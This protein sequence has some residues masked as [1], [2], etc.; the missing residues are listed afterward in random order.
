M[1]STEGPRMAKGDI[2]GDGLEDVYIC[3]AKDQA[4]VIYEQTREGRFKK[5]N[6]KLFE[7]DKLSEDTDALFFDA[8][9]DGDEDLYVCSGGNE[10]SPN[11]TALIDRLYING[12]K[13]KFTMSPQVLPSYIFEAAVA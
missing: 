10:F 5:S 2:N 12:G 6:E 8:D 13:G 1:L 4:G 11:S 7:T 3:G 9:G